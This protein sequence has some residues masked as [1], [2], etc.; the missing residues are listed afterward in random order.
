[1]LFDLVL[2][3]SSSHIAVVRLSLTRYRIN[4][5]RNEFACCQLTVTE[6]D[7][8]FDADTLDA[9]LAA[10]GAPGK[11]RAHIFYAIRIQSQPFKRSG[12]TRCS[13]STTNT[14]VTKFV[15]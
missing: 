13:I 6:S 12:S 15:F 5:E 11:S 7:V 8:A 4:T 2:L 9:G 3:C 14:C 10:L 1:M